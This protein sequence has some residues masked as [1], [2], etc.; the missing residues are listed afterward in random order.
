MNDNEGLSDKELEKKKLDAQNAD[1]AKAAGRV[2]LNAQLG[3]VGDA[4]ANTELYDKVGDAAGKTL[5]KVNKFVPRSQKT[6][7]A[8]SDS[9]ATDLTNEINNSLNGNKDGVKSNIQDK[10]ASKTSTSSSSEQETKNSNKSNLTSNDIFKKVKVVVVGGLIVILFAITLIMSLSGESGNVLSRGEYNTFYQ[11]LDNNDKEFKNLFETE[12]KVL[13]KQQEKF[14]NRVDR[15]Y[16]N[17]MNKTLHP[18]I[19]KYLEIAPLGYDKDDPATKPN[20]EE[21]EAT[22]MHVISTLFVEYTPD[23]FNESIDQQQSAY[24]DTSAYKVCSEDTGCAGAIPEED[25]TPDGLMANLWNK[26]KTAEYYRKE[27]DDVR[28]LVRNTIVYKNVC[29]LQNCD[30][31]GWKIN[32]LKPFDRECKKEVIEEDKIEY[33]EM[34][35]FKFILKKATSV[36]TLGLSSIFERNFWHC[37]SHLGGAYSLAASAFAGIE[38]KGERWDVAN[39]KLVEDVDLCSYYEWLIEDD[40]L[41]KKNRIKED[42]KTIVSEKYKD[43]LIKYKVQYAKEIVTAVDLSDT[44]KPITVLEGS[45]LDLYTVSTD[46]LISVNDTATGN[47]VGVY[48]IDLYVQGVLSREVGGFYNKRKSL[49]VTDDQVKEGWKAMAI[50]IRSYALSRT[51]GG[52]SSIGNTAAAQVFS[53]EIL[54]DDNVANKDYALLMRA[55]ALETSGLVL[56]MNNQIFSAEYDSYYKGD[57]HCDGNF[58]YSKYLLKGN[59]VETYHWV[60]I[61]A[62]WESMANGGHGRGMSQIGVYYLAKEG[63]SF[64]QMLDYFYG[65]QVSIYY[66]D[67]EDVAETGVNNKNNYYA[68]Q[69][70]NNAEFAGEAILA[71]AYGIE[72]PLRTTGLTN[73]DIYGFAGLKCKTVGQSVDGGVCTQANVL[74]TPSNKNRRIINEINGIA[75]GENNYLALANYDETLVTNDLSETVKK[76]DSQP[77]EIFGTWDDVYTGNLFVDNARSF[78]GKKDSELDYYFNVN[79]AWSASFV[80]FIVKV[81]P[82]TNLDFRSNNVRNWIYHFEDM[83]TYYHSDYYSSII[84]NPSYYNS[85]K[86]INDVG[87][88]AGDIIFFMDD[89]CNYEGNGM[90]DDMQYLKCYKHMGIVTYVGNDTLTYV[91]G[92]T[93]SCGSNGIC[94]STI[95][96][97]DKYI[98]GYGKY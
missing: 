79:E 15:I 75:S 17:Y 61:P 31:N 20:Y 90:M 7:S 72:I 26:I 28:K 27:A 97:Y 59:K 9:G 76:E 45:K 3:K 23:T 78:V 57:Y 1:V 48:P 85:F 96:K 46:I 13:I 55:A 14:L 36:Y 41:D 8:L 39:Y 42:L 33:E 32:I 91:H 38:N 49:G 82:N 60:K 88:N 24:E 29:V 89:A 73:F 68:V 25:Y 40:Y 21:F 87:I 95:S 77:Y 81:T 67:Y 22:K 16:R 58:C 83:N 80:S 18:G 47:A 86:S 84:N 53:P 44:S 69:L 74:D 62:S 52:V 71:C 56:R 94:E 93:T 10:A 5:T 6:M 54:T 98:V 50:A 34:S 37:K 35:F 51:K 66:M 11:N 92:N 64:T 70:G 19:G 30:S 43:D 12:D 4:I 65:D 63:R 2:Y